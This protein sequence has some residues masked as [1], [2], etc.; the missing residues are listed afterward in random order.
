MVGIKVSE[1][2]VTSI[3]SSELWWLKWEFKRMNRN[4]WERQRLKFQN[5][6]RQWCRECDNGMYYCSFAE[7]GDSIQLSKLYPSIYMRSYPTV[8]PMTAHERP[9]LALKTK[10][11]TKISLSL[12]YLLFTASSKPLISPRNDVECAFN[13]ND[14][15]PQVSEDYSKP[16][17]ISCA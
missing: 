17:N 11:H 2:H 16:A 10:F 12:Y 15:I 9:S 7:I 4:T 3:N 13:S 14:P 5:L 8:Y 6:W 1:N